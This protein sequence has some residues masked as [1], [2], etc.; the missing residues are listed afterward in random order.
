MR[1]K[2]KVEG[3]SCEHCVNSVE[4]MLKEIKGV[5]FVKVQLPNNVEVEFDDNLLDIKNIKEKVNE[6]GVYK[7]I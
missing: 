2:F 1:V 4:S 7:A 3:L 5:T 6:T